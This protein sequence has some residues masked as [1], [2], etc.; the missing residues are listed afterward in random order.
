[1]AKLRFAVFIIS[2]FVLTLG[3]SAQTAAVRGVVED[4]AKAPIAGATVTLR[5]TINGAERTATTDAQGRFSFDGSIGSGQYELVAESN[6]F[7]RF[8]K[9]IGP[10]YADVVLTLSPGPIQEDVTV[11]ATRTQISSAD[12]AVPVSVVDREEIERKAVNSIGDIFRTL[13]GTSTATEGPSRCVRVSE[14]STA[15]AC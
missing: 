3:V 15:T 7:G 14:G 4:S 9:P 11:T 10:E 8:V 6:G 5:N 12:T 1:M 2:L 13:P